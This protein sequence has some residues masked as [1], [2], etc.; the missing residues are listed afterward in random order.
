VAP[1]PPQRVVTRTLQCSAGRLVSG[2]YQRDV[3]T[4]ANQCGIECH[5]IPTPGLFR[6]R[7]EI[8]LTG[9]E[10]QVNDAM[11]YGRV[12]GKSSTRVDPGTIPYGG[13]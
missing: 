9:P 3:T 11:T 4:F 12:L 10:E 8:T 1:A 13:L 2:A 7:L 5:I 6:T